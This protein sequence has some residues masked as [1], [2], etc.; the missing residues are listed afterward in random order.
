MVQ[1]IKLFEPIAGIH[2]FH[3]VWYLWV[4][5]VIYYCTPP[6]TSDRQRQSARDCIKRV[7]AEVMEDKSESAI[8]AS[9]KK[10]LA[11]EFTAGIRDDHWLID[12]L[13]N[14]APD[15]LLKGL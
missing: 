5:D 9:I 10:A 3:S 14:E 1:A 12:V 4:T 2:G 6:A 15:E 8:I 13:G 11:E 7:I